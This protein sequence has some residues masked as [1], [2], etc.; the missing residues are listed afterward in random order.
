MSVLTQG[1]QFSFLMV[2]ILIVIVIVIMSHFVP[3]FS[4]TKWHPNFCLFRYNYIN[5]LPTEHTHHSHIM[6]SLWLRSAFALAS[7]LRWR[8][9]VSKLEWNRPQPYL[10]I[11]RMSETKNCL[12]RF[13]FQWWLLLVT[14]YRTVSFDDGTIKRKGGRYAFKLRIETSR[15]WL[16]KLENRSVFYISIN[17]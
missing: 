8:Q 4:H 14:F 12:T 16:F 3:L 10:S 15:E 11:K 17:G 2:C 13:T 6:P 7:L 5:N 9:S 1:I